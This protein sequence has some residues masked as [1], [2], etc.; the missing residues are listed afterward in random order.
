[1]KLIQ[2]LLLVLLIFCLGC[3][4][5]SRTVEKI[6]NPSIPHLVHVRYSEGSS[7]SQPCA[8]CHEEI[9]HEWASSFHAQATISTAFKSESDHY[10]FKRCITCHAPLAPASG[11]SRPEGRTWKIEEGITCS[12]CHVVGDRT[13]GPIESSA[14]HGTLK[15]ETFSDSKICA[16]CHEP[17]YQEWKASSFFEN[18]KTCQSCHMPEV[19]RYLSNMTP[20]LYRK[21]KSHDHGFGINF[22]NVVDL[23]ISTSRLVPDQIVIHVTNTGS[24]HSIPTGIYGDA[25]LFV[26]LRIFDGDQLVFFREEKLSAKAGNSIK[27]GEKRRFFYS[28]RPP[29]PKSYLIVARVFFASSNYENDQKL[30]EVQRYYYDSNR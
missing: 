9:Y 14:P 18:G 11:T 8:K 24:G 22:E 16:S 10:E 26:D 6:L 17:T 3:S 19:T 7:G 4:K 2:F 30:A 15:D 29:G 21:K 28:F 27:A 1:M 5:K 23:K 25:T 20:H 12:S 13:A